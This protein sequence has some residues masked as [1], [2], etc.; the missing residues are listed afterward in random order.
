M[1]GL[2]W[3]LDVIEQIRVKEDKSGYFKFLRSSYSILEVSCLKNKGGRFLEIVDYHSRAQRGS[4]R[5]PEGSKSA[6]WQKLASEIWSFFLGREGKSDAP[7]FIPVGGGPGKGEKYDYGKSRFLGSS[8]D[9]RKRINE[10]APIKQ[11]AITNDSCAISNARIV[12]DP[13]SPRPTRKSNF[14]WNPTKNTLR[15]TKIQGEARQ[16]HWVKIKHKVVGLAQIQQNP[17]AHPVDYIDTE[18]GYVKPAKTS[19]EVNAST[20]GVDPANPEEVE[21]I[22]CD[23]EPRATGGAP[24]EPV[25]TNDIPELPTL[26]MEVSGLPS[27][28]TD[29][30]RSTE[31]EVVNEQA[32]VVRVDLVESESARGS[33]LTMGHPLL[34]STDYEVGEVSETGDAEIQI[35][36]VEYYSFED[37]DGSSPVYCS[38]LA[39]IRPAECS[40]TV[41]IS[42]GSQEEFS[43]WVKKHYKGFCKLVGFPIDTHKQQCLDLLQRIEADKFKYNTTNKRK[44]PAGSARK[45]SRGLRNLVSSI[46]YDGRS[47]GC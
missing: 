12:L 39:V 44:Q 1:V 10:I 15:I 45:G 31:E 43:Q 9:P 3:L 29:D 8:R 27:I 14:N 7:M 37:L 2:K 5:I 32:V 46:N 18:P 13:E 11:S 17:K 6:G 19:L 28:T 34:Q 21:T 33:A 25:L 26:T 24:S 4:V 41:V 38:P 42:D 30:C 22:S 16:A 36:A 23:A 47:L 35:P 20:S 40:N